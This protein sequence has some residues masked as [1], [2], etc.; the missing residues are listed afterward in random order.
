[1]SRKR[2]RHKGDREINESSNNRINNN[3]PF[4]INPANL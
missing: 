1:M 2:H 4:G 3:A